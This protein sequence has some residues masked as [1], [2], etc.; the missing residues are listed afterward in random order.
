MYTCTFMSLS[1]QPIVW[2]QSTIMQVQV[3]SF[4]LLFWDFHALCR[5]YTDCF[6]KQKKNTS[7]QQFCLGNA[8]TGEVREE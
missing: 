1:K 3:K 8:L 6:E 7:E 5:V 2:Q 4:S